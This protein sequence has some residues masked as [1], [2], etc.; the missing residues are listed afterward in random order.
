MTGSGKLEE[1][2]QYRFRYVK[3][4]EVGDQ[5]YMVLQSPYGSRHLIPA[6]PYRQWGFVKGS[7]LLCRVDKVNCKNEIFL[8]PEHPVYKVGEVYSFRLGGKTQELRADGSWTTVFWLEDALGETHPLPDSL[9]KEMRS[10]GIQLKIDRIKKGA[11]TFSSAGE[12]KA[13]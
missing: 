13:D 1:G 11:F 2:K 9:T 3:D 8:E 5:G 12:Q 6:G 4:T 10:G 7:L